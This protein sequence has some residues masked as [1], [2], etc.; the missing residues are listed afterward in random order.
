[1]K[2]F[3]SITGKKK[4]RLS[5]NSEVHLNADWVDHQSAGVAVPDQ[6]TDHL[7][8]ILRTVDV[9]DDLV[10][11]ALART[12]DP[13]D[14]PD[15]AGRIIQARELFKER[16][17]S[18]DLDSL[19]EFLDPEQY[20]DNASLAENILFGASNHEMFSSSGLAE[21]PVLRALLVE[22]KLAA[23]LD[24]AA[25]STA[26]TMVEL[27][28]G[29]PQGHEFFDRYSF[30]DADDL[31]R[32]KR[33]LGLL[34]KDDNIDDLDA[35]DRKLLRSLPFGLIR[36]RHRL[37]I[38]DSE[39]KQKILQLRRSFAD[40]LDQHSL[41]QIDFFAPDKYNALT[42]IAENIIF[43][44]VAFGRLGAEDK[45]YQLLLEVLRSLDLMSPILEIG[46][47][48]PAGL[49]GS[50]LPVSQR[51][52]LILARGLIKQPK[53]LVINEGLSALD[54][55]E[56]Q[57]ILENLKQSYPKMCLFWV[58]NQARFADLFDRFVHLQ[59]GKITRVEEPSASA[60]DELAGESD[61]SRSAVRSAYSIEEDEK[62]AL[63]N[64]I[65]LFRFMDDPHLVLLARNCDALNVSKGERLFNQGDPGD[66]LYIIVDGKATILMSDGEQERQVGESGINEVIGELA[67]LSNE[68]RAASVEAATDLAVL[69]LKQDVFTNMLQSNGEIAYQILQVVV[70]RFADTNRKLANLAQ[71]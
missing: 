39:D 66:A 53:V 64:S 6:L 20:N 33:I 15:L 52:K 59:A 23:T 18:Q 70:G 71:S 68:P 60:D 5:G 42:P 57:R 14:N 31:P 41:Q 54:S 67:L 17:L 2:P 30:I 46:L 63:L 56:I 61:D 9:E 49:A 36:G 69:R 51:Q 4:P 12:I 27:F 32:L 13:E 19:V 8:A 40:K 28:S 22:H 11:Y 43:G 38:L 16:I 24:D 7:G 48:A 62:L 37:G 55:D 1:M 25:L 47:A 50:L 21:H 10:R 26:T 3:T 34:E 58:D 29:L 44:R 45:V 65:P 35:A